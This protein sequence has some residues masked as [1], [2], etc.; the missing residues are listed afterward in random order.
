MRGWLLR[1]G[2]RIGIG[3]NPLASLTVWGLFV[4]QASA[5]IAE[6]VCTQGHDLLPADWCPSVEGFVLGF[7]QVLTFFGIR[8]AVK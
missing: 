7:G 1:L 8:R 6:L 3:K 4:W 5:K 2:T